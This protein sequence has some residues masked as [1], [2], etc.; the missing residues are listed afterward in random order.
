MIT[1]FKLAIYLRAYK[2][3]VI[4]GPFFK[5]LEAIFEL[6]LP[7]IVALIIIKGIGMRD[8]S[9]VFKM[10]ALMLILSIVGFGC[11]MICQYYAARASQGFGTT[12]RNKIF[13]HISS[14][15]YAEMDK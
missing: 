4:I 13:R 6:L 12:L 7:T 8:T 15:S 9:Y 11:S 3:E 1:L 5:L 14:L 10:G 2:K